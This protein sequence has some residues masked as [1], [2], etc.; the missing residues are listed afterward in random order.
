MRRSYPSGAQKRE[1]RKR[2]DEG[3]HKVIS[4]TK[5]IS[6]FFSVGN[7]SNEEPS[8]SLPTSATSSQ[9]SP[10]FSCQAPENSPFQTNDDW[11]VPT[12][13]LSSSIMPQN[14]PDSITHLPIDP[15][16]WQLNDSVWNYYTY[17]T[18]DL[19]QNVDKIDLK[20]TVISS[21]SQNRCLTKSFFSRMPNGE[22]VNRFWLSFSESTNTIMCTACKLFSQVKSQFTI[23]FKKMY[24]LELS[25]MKSQPC[26]KAQYQL[27]FLAEVHVIY[28][29]NRPK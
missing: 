21:G 9:S 18:N 6:V 28:I 16:R 25:P 1:A 14:N 8:T 29:H 3:E 23:G 2:K 12:S 27:G 13:S 11:Q 19:P 5:P 7:A 4:K 10:S 24:M 17:T 15:A 22:P 20:K 26:T